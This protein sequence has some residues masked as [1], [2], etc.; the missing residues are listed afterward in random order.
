MNLLSQNQSMGQLEIDTTLNFVCSVLSQ[1][2]KKMKKKNNFIGRKTV[3]V[4]KIKSIAEIKR[5]IMMPDK[6]LFLQKK[7]SENY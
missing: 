7:I 2:I 3:V 6:V 1:K 5:M 4:G